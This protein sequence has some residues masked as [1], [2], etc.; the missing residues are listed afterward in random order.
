MGGRAAGIGGIDD[1][2]R[3]SQWFIRLALLH[4]VLGFTFGA[5]M[6]ANKGLPLHPALWRLLP[7]HIEL[8]LVGWT[9]Q[10]ALGV[11]FWILPRFLTDQPRGSEAGAWL[12]FILLNGGLWLFN[13]GTFFGASQ[14]VIFFGRLAEVT[15]VA[16]FAWHIWPRIIPRN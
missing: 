3:L 12:A 7:L 10:L 13:L 8:L 15:A 1:M 6:L 9:M 5:L 4:L 14:I 2:P 11:A 16:A